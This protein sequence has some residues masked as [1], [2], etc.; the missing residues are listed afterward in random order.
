MAPAP[1]GPAETAP[2]EVKGVTP[3]EIAPK[4]PDHPGAAVAVE[5]APSAAP[6]PAGAASPKIAMAQPPPPP[7]ATSRMKPDNWITYRDARFGF[8]LNYPADVFTSAASDGAD[9]GERL[10]L[11][12][13]GRALLWI[14][15]VADATSPLTEYRRALMRGRYRG[16]IFDYT[17]VRSNWFVLSGT[18]GEEMFYERV[19]FSCDGRTLHRWL[20]VYP[21]AER[22]FFDGIVEEVHRSYRYD[23]GG[24][25]RC[26]GSTSVQTPP[27]DV[28]GKTG[29]VAGTTSFQ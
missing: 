4:E 14:S 26:N 29:A 23:L 7:P 3:A 22:A 15:A 17:P 9:A 20:L 13:D 5:R 19:T 11:T 24:R 21:L 12:K 2:S 1:P 10:L 16:A 27:D 18:A 6:D 8:A 28:P 25:A